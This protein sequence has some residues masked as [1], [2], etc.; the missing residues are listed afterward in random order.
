MDG[1][2]EVLRNFKSIS[3]RTSLPNAGLRRMIVFVAVRPLKHLSSEDDVCEVVGK[4]EYWRNVSVKAHRVP[5]SG[6]MHK[7]RVR[8][9]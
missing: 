5:I 3:V 9:S 7:G 6:C 8:W 2:V 1:V 4:A